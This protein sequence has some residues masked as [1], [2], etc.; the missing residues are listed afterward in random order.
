MS[1]GLQH[2]LVREM[3]GN[4]RHGDN[5]RGV[6]WTRSQATADTRYGVMLDLLRGSEPATVLD[7]GC[8]AAHL[9]EYLLA[10]GAPHV[11]YSGLDLSPAYLALCRSKHP[12]VTFFECDVLSDSCAVPVHDYVLMNGIF[13]Y[14]G[15]FSFD[16]MWDYC[17]KMLLKANGLAVKGFA[18]NAMSK[19]V[20]WERDDLFHLPLDTVAEFL[21]RNVSRFFTVRHD[22][23][24]YEYTVYV[25][26]APPAP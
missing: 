20:D 11:R 22:Y 1:P 8:G 10:R 18:F 23:G 24:L 2:E 14:K 9:Y 26:K 19:H 25:Y 12:H 13:N 7:L 4:L 17:R 6:G 16:E 3:E 5:Y 15:R 21:H